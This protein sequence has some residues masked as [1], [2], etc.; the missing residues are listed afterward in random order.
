MINCPATLTTVPTIGHRCHVLNAVFSINASWVLLIPVGTRYRVF[1]SFMFKRASVPSWEVGWFGVLH[2]GWGA[3]WG[4]GDAK[5]YLRAQV[6][7]S[8]WR[9]EEEGLRL[10]Q[11]WMS[12]LR[13]AVLFTVLPGDRRLAGLGSSMQILGTTH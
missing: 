4:A 13:P 8:G 6:P 11:G 7:H 10:P 5:E 3:G 2:L 9:A 12:Q 1:F